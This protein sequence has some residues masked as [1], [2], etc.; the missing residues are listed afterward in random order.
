MSLRGL[1]AMKSQALIDKR[2]PSRIAWPVA[3]V[4]LVTGAALVLGLSGASV[5]HPVTGCLLTGLAVISY[6]ADRRFALAT[7]R[8]EADCRSGSWRSCTAGPSAPC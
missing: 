3:I 5:R 8:L 4:L 2:D 1:M 7:W 6:L